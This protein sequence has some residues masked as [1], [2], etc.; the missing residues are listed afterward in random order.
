MHFPRNLSLHF[1]LL[2]N[3][4]QIFFI[5]NLIYLIIKITWAY[6][7]IHKFCTWNFAVLSFQCYEEEQLKMSHSVSRGLILWDQDSTKWSTNCEITVSYLK[8]LRFTSTEPVKMGQLNSCF[9]AGVL[10]G[11]LLLLSL[12]FSPSLHLW[13]WK[14]KTGSCS[15]LLLVNACVYMCLC[16]IASS[17]PLAWLLH[18]VREQISGWMIIRSDCSF[19]PKKKKI[20]LDCMSRTFYCLFL[21]VLATWLFFIWW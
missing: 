19:L 1:F 2:I 17:Y 8:K 11:S 10:R 13:P 7:S 4:C 5:Q 14:F 6:T 15:A 21:P 12:S 3:S 16:F 18:P 20:T 9:T